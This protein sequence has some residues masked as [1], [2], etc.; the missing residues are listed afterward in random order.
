M[1]DWHNLKISECY[2]LLSTS[3]E[4]LSTK[5]AKKRIEKWGKNELPK[6]K[7]VPAYKIF[8]SQFKNALI[9]ILLFTGI[10][11]VLT[12][13]NKEAIVIF[14]AVLINVIIGFRQEYKASQAL[15]KLRQLVEHKAYVIRDGNEVVIESSLLVPGDIILI[16]SGDRLPADARII[17]ASD[18]LIDESM[19]TGESIPS[20]KTIEISPKGAALADRNCMVFAG[21]VAVNGIGQ[22]VIVETGQTTEIGKI[23]GMVETAEE[24][25]TP[26]QKRLSKFS[27][28][29]GIIFGIIC[30]IIVIIGLLQGRHFKE[31][32]ETGVA[33]GV[34]SIPEG[35]TVAVTFILALGMQRILKEKALTRKL[36]AAE[37]LGSTTV[38]CSDKTGTLTEGKM[39]VAHIII[40]ENEYELK[41]LG[42]RQDPAEAEAVSLALQVGMMCNDAN[43]ENP[44][45]ELSVWRFIGSPTEV[46]LLKA[47]IQAGLNKKMLLKNEP[48]I[49]EV[50][51][52]SEKKYMISLHRKGENQYRLYEKGAPEI[53]LGKSKY[54]FH[55]GK[56]REL[57]GLE[58]EKLK[59]TY[60]SLTSRGLRV[61]GVA[62][63]D[64]S[65]SSKSFKID[66]ND[67]N[68]EEIDCELVFVGFIALKDPLRPEAADTIRI[69]REAG[70]K[71]VIITGDHKLTAKAIA[72]EVGIEVKP[73][74]IMLGKDM[75]G[76]NDSELIKMV[77]KINVYARV[78]PHHKLRIV[79]A[80]QSAGE[81]VAMTGDGI[82]DSPAL[83]V[84]DIG[85]SFG[86]GTDIAKE[87]SDIVLLDNNYKT[88]VS[89]VKQGRVI[90]KNIRKVITY[91]VSD[92][93]SEMFLIIGSIIFNTPLAVLP[94]Q[95]LW[96][97]IVN[98]SMPHFS[99]AFEKDHG[100]VMKEKPIKQDEPLLNQRMKMIIFGVGIV[101][102]LVLFAL[103]FYLYHRWSHTPAK[104]SYLTTLMFMILGVKSLISIFSLRSFSRS[105]WKYNPFSNRYMLLAVSGSMALLVLSIYW[106]P[107]RNLLGNSSEIDWIAWFVTILFA[108]I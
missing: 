32:L 81:V 22:A 69:A 78:S 43:V 70:I 65:L 28:L 24:E 77:K 60:E 37:T 19:L 14:S 9:Y 4:G 17:E 47:A 82:N 44:D 16:K 6:E 104:L 36:V 27:R 2:K 95:I 15:S 29:L 42:S 48:K 68:W 51:F 7:I 52:S 84:A 92:S 66:K 34:S 10:L 99:L 57:K 35:M 30:V 74:N 87:T 76:I 21:T 1:K 105:I 102:D 5:Q 72:K 58:F 23:A 100:D 67:I 13:S 108:G 80:L 93:F 40:G 33:I 96:I 88:I 106:S 98:D 45:D 103:F 64:Y 61:V 90:F 38:I 39:H 94:A 31:M 54:F 85:V 107:L 53:L 101:R 73:E 83:K 75:D 46:A 3:E 56:I 25:K 55:K 63:K 62:Q 71:A 18:L 12:D 8:I 20:H 49:A 86:N 97:N 89:A 91:L 59:K 50:P 41:T 79:K 26:L 11:S